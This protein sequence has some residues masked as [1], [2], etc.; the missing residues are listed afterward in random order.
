MKKSKLSEAQIIA[1]INEGEAGVSVNDICRRYKIS[2][3]TYYKL[4]GKYSG[5]SL[6]ELTRLKALET[7]NQ[8]LKAMYADISVEYKIV[9][10]VLEKKYPEL[11]DKD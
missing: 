8:R 5:M 2:S 4:K 7:E 9:K 10:E 6:S 1:M 11:I 3:A